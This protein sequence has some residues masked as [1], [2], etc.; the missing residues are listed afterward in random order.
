MLQLQIS[1]SDIIV[2]AF[3]SRSLLQVPS[4]WQTMW[5]KYQQGSALSRNL[6]TGEPYNNIT[7]AYFARRQQQQ[8]TGNRQQLR[9]NKQ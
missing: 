7:S 3:N 9:D 6:L 1:E 5:E 4:R 8:A 2:A